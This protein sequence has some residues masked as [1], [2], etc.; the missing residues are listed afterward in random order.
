MTTAVT[1]PAPGRTRYES[2][3][4]VKRIPV[5]ISGTTVPDCACGL[6]GIDAGI[7]YVRAERQIPESSSIVVSFDH[8]QLSGVVAGCQG[9]EGEWVISVALGSCKRRLDERIPN[10]EET[11][12]GVIEGDRTTQHP[13]TIID[14]SSFGLGLCL[15]TPID[16]G[17]RVCVETESMMVFG[18]IRHCHTR[19]D[20]Q[21][22]A[23]VLIIDVVPDVRTQNMF[24]VMLHSLRWKLASSIRGKDV[25]AYRA[26]H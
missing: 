18:E 25:P 12:I 4:A 1:L 17:A 3:K 15:S 10:G 5:H 14:T 13:C 26:N 22:T 2:P 11:V 24:S 16:A 21:F 7:L 20:G 8:V 23:G 19:P 9:V 6:V